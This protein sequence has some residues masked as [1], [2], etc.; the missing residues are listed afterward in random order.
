AW[1]R[2]GA[3]GRIATSRY[4][5]KKSNLLKLKV[6]VARLG[7]F[8]LGKPRQTK[9]CPNGGR[10][11]ITDEAGQRR[12]ICKVVRGLVVRFI[13][14]FVTDRC[15]VRNHGQ[16]RMSHDATPRERSPRRLSYWDSNRAHQTI[17]MKFSPDGRVR[18][19]VFDHRATEAAPSRLLHRGTALLLP[20]EFQVALAVRRFHARSHQDR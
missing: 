14:G 9:R 11:W 7:A 16:R 19:S 13:T 10:H 1:C 12:E 2:R 17:C 18:D 5:A 20:D 4:L 3:T 6:S 8:T 15:L